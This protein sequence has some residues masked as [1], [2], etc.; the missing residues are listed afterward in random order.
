[1]SM[2]PTRVLV[3]PEIPMHERLADLFASSAGSAAGYSA[4]STWL[5]CPEK[6]RLNSKGVRRRRNL[7]DDSRTLSAL[8]FGTLIHGLRAIRFAYG[9]QAAMFTLSRWANEMSP[10]DHTKASLLLQTCESIYPL[11]QEPLRILGIEVE[12]RSSV[13]KRADGSDIIRTVRYDTVVAA[14]STDD[15]SPP[16]V[17]SFEAKTMSKSG[18]NALQPYIPQAMGQVALWNANPD[19]VATFGP[20]RGV[21]F[22]CWVKTSTPG[23][24]RVGPSYFSKLHQRLALKYLATPDTQAMFTVGPDGRFPQM[25]HACWGRF[26]ACDY[27]NICHEEA[28]GDYELRDGSPYY[29]D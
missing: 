12:V 6:S 1:M 3:Q 8:D 25:L 17:F 24:E 5:T 27:M 19:L 22:D 26:S 7:S 18:S 10:E 23:V 11:E 4:V 29:G 15:N 2:L 20:M 13:G 14:E 16:G 28:Y 21:I 9:H